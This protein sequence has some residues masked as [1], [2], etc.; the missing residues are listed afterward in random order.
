MATKTEKY[1][2][3]MPEQN[4]NY[5]INVHNENARKI[6]AAMAAMQAKID[7]HLEE[8]AKAIPSTEKGAPGGV[9]SLDENGK[10]DADQLPE[11]THLASEI[12]EGT[13]AGAVRAKDDTDYT[14]Y[15]LRNCALMPAVP[16]S[17]ASGTFALVYE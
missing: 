2:L 12:S 7:E 13:F 4:E 15:K 16:S 11:H 6:D 10:L 17:M 14:A 9:A 5:D 1:G 3:T 8:A